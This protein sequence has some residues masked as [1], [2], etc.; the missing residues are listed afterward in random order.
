MSFSDH[1]MLYYKGERYEAVLLFIFGWIC[2]FISLPIIG[3]KTSNPLSKGLLYPIIALTVVCMFAGGYNAW[4]NNNRLRIMPNK[5]AKDAS[6]FIKMETRRFEGANGVN[7]WWLPLKI[8]WIVF[9]IA[10]SAAT[11]FTKS[12][13]IHGNAIGLIIWGCF[14]MVVDGFAHHR[15]KIY[16]AQLL[17]Q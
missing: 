3:S 6:A 2:L 11:L 17:Q 10:G 15:A 13:F 4:N 12:D 14:G 7:S 5:Y 16:T 9:L 8:T 1:I